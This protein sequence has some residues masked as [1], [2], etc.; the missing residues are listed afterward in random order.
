MPRFGKILAT[1]GSV[2]ALAA[3]ATG[4]SASA[5]PGPAGPDAGNGDPDRPETVR[6]ATFNASLY[7][8]AKGE[9]LADLSTPDDPQA[10]EVAE[11]VQRKRPDVLLL[12]EFDHAGG[13]AAVNA[14]R[15]NY[16]ERSQHGARPIHYP[17][18]YTAPVNTGV[19]SGADLNNDGS[20]GGPGDAFGYGQFPGQYGMVVLSKHP[21]ATE[22]VR[23]FRE[24]RWADMPGALLPDDPST[25]RPADWYSPREL[26]RV[27]LSSKSHWDVPIVVDGAPVHFL[28]SHPTPP[29]FDGPENRNGRRNHDEIRFWADYV[30]PSGKPYIYDDSGR[31]G[32]LEP[33]ARFVIAGDQN[34]DPHDGDSFDRAARQLL[35]AHRVVDP[36]P[37][38]RGAVEASR[39]QGGAN[40]SH[41][42]PAALDTA[43]FG[44]DGS[45]NL[46]VDFV[47]PSLPL[48]P[49]G[50]GVFWPTSG[51]EFARLR[52]VSDHHL[53]WVDVRA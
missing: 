43:D 17:Y 35:D 42:G 24:F 27:R 9:L 38:S 33:G 32:G 19:S 52:D 2:V 40:D 22:R 6:F 23:T 20:V 3:S 51:S 31:L 13:Y 48:I 10:R 5:A 18:A 7:R 25:P 46:R 37:S 36:R 44:D 8:D 21:I 28:V 26:S 16:L 14:F 45:G 39:A 15:D 30:D 49:V 50:S 47:L 34:A 1:L 4:V 41:T 53:V 11:V 29:V 12:N